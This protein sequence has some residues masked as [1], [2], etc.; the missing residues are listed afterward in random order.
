[1]RRKAALVTQVGTDDFGRPWCTLDD[2][3]LQ[4]GDRGRVGPFE[5]TCVRHSPDGRLLHYMKPGADPCVG[6][7]L[8]VTRYDSRRSLPGGK[9][10][11]NL[12]T[13]DPR[14]PA[15][16]VF[17]HHHAPNRSIGRSV[18]SNINVSCGAR[19]NAT[20]DRWG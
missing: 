14:E 16:D 3:L 6:E 10:E 2:S 9:S 18:G 5:L 13:R 19:D 4:P 20:V 11:G 17:G 15:K 7:L 12:D 1:M 8:G